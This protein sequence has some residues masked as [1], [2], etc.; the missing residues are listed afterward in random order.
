MD[1]SPGPVPLHRGRAG[2]RGPVPARGRQPGAHAQLRGD[3]LRRRRHGH[4]PLPGRAARACGRAT[5]S[6]CGPASGTGTRAASGS[7]CTTAASAASCCAASCPGPGRTRCSATCCG[8]ARTRRRG[9]GVLAFSLDPAPSAVPG[10]PGRAH[11]AAPL[12]AD[13]YR[14]DVLG[15]L[16]L[17]LSE[18]GRAVAQAAARRPASR[19]GRI[20]RS[21]GRCACWRPT[22]PARWTLTE[23][24]DGAAPGPRLPGPAVQGR[25]RAAAHG[26]PGPGA[27]RARRGP[28]AA[29]R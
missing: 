23:L 7:S 1:T 19:A 16:S 14:G 11:R 26:L 13:R 9:R 3:R 22:S 4:P 2:L 29:L 10:P 17:L 6:C 5:S 21:G 15:R 8:P 24:A 20:R 12:P 28:A 27:R 25:H 18:L